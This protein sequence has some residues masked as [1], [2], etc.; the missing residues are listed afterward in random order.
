MSPLPVSPLGKDNNDDDSDR[1]EFDELEDLDFSSASSLTPPPPSPS[2]MLEGREERKGGLPIAPSPAGA[3]AGTAESVFNPSVGVRSSLPTAPTLGNIPLRPQQPARPSGGYQSIGVLTSEDLI[4]NDFSRWEYLEEHIKET[5]EWAQETLSQKGMTEDVGQARAERGEKYEEMIKYLDRMIMSHIS[6]QR[7][8]PTSD[9]SYLVARV[10]NEIL[11]L[12]PLEPLWRDRSITEIIAAGPDTVYI[13]RE[14]K[15][16]SVPGARF[17]G[18]GH[19]LQLCQQILAPLNRSLDV[20]NPLEDGRLPDKSRVNA[21]HTA[22][23]PNGPL[24]TIRRHREEAW[25]MKELV[26]RNSMSED[27]A[28]EIGY[29]VNSGCSTIVIGGTGTGKMLSH[30][31][32]LPTPDGFTTMG[33][34]NVGDYVLDD[35]GVPTKVTAK[36]SLKDPVPYRVVFSDGTEVLA[37]EDHNWL[38]ATRAAR[39]SSSYAEKVEHTRVR[40]QRMSNDEIAVIQARLAEL[41]DSDDEEFLTR[42]D[43]CDMLPE[44]VSMLS[45]FF[46]SCP[47]V[48]GIQEEVEGAGPGQVRYRYPQRELLESLVS[49]GSALVRDQRHM[50]T[51]ESVV[52][53]KEILN[54]LKTS[55]GHTNHAVRVLRSPVKHA[56]KTQEVDPFLVGQELADA[57]AGNASTAVENAS[58]VSLGAIDGDSVRIPKNYRFGSVEQRRALLAGFLERAGRFSDDSPLVKIQLKDAAL[59]QDFSSVIASLGEK[60]L[61]RKNEGNGAKLSFTPTLANP[62]IGSEYE[63]DYEKVFSSHKDSPSTAKNEWRYIVDVIPVEDPVEMSCIT[64]DSPTSLYLCS[65]HYVITHNTTVLNAISGLI[66]PNEYVVTI[67]DNL[68]LQLHPERMVASLE[69]RP[70][71]ANQ[72]GAISIRD[73]VRNALRMRPDRVVVGEVRDAAAFDMLQAMNTG[74]DGSLTTFHANGADE[75]VDRLESMVQM[76][77]ELDPRGVKALIASAVDVIVVASRYEDGSRRV[78]GVYEMPSRLQVDEGGN[79]VLHPVPL[80]EFVH[81]ETTAQGQVVGHYEKKNDVSE[82]L[83]R[84]HRLNRKPRLSIEEIYELGRL[85]NE[86]DEEEF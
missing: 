58:L 12:G 37:D 14:G 59:L 52:T 51:T 74:H 25:T 57:A 64:V 41:S 29:L 19:L 21:V 6:T 56:E 40:S 2:E 71:G 84:K 49:Y 26:E 36:Y 70:A 3:G 60:T 43:L 15:L 81:T 24:L 13:E 4:N 44:R 46:S 30:D 48:L 18:P 83:I 17:R 38:T 66:P 20:A 73:L 23:A 69:A 63:E 42:R 45:S 28:M 5:A 86:D 31:T 65:E 80:W 10:T 33:A 67:E 50:R 11:G 8:I 76:A 22:I 9:R 77:G 34:V 54:S 55:T 27:V 75:A 1:I 79:Q 82:A 72:R 61:F 7:Q 47:D 62:F 53:T 85:H 39:R 78:S 32:V 35:N 68:E 16:S